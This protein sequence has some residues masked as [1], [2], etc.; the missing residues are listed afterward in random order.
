MVWQGGG[1]VAPTSDEN[2]ILM[3]SSEVATL[4]RIEAFP[5]LRCICVEFADKMVHERAFTPSVAFRIPFDQK[6]SQPPTGVRRRA[7][8]NKQLQGLTVVGE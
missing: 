4:E 7:L 5:N 8:Q 6:K 3:N 2:T 1:P